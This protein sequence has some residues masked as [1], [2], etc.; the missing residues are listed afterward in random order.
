L[1][2]GKWTH[3]RGKA[4]TPGQIRTADLLIRGQTLSL[5]SD[6]FEEELITPNSF[7]SSFD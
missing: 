7:P 6:L 3:I 5:F 2:K 4:G 1:P